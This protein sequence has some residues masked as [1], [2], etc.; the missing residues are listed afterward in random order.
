MKLTRLLREEQQ[1]DR[2]NECHG[3]RSAQTGA[4]QGAGGRRVRRRSILR[5]SEPPGP[6]R[7]DAFVSALRLWLVVM[8]RG[9]HPFP[10]RTRPLSPVA[11]MV[12]LVYPVGEYVAANLSSGPSNLT[13]RGAFC[14]PL[15]RDGTLGHLTP[16]VFFPGPSGGHEVSD[17]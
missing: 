10:S 8:A 5:R 4:G 16:H 6:Q 12:L 7:R 17:P 1:K 13:V 11:R 14:F 9:T 2:L 3:D 15:R